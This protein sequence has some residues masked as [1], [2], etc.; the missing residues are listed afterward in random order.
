MSI[1]TWDVAAHVRAD[2]GEGPAWDDRENVLWFVDVT[3]GALYRLDP[4][5]GEVESRL[6]GAPMGSAIPSREGG[7]ILALEDGVHAYSWDDD[8]SRLLVPVEAHDARIRMND[9]KCDPHGRLWAGTMAYEFTPGVSTLYRFDRTGPTPVETGCTIANGMGWSPDTATM[10][11]V[12]SPTSRIDI[13]DYD[14]ET[15]AATD[16]R[17]WV[18]V[19]D[20]AG[21]PDGLT[22]DS[23]GCIW[24]ALWGGGAVRRYAPDGKLIEVVDLP[25][26]Q[27]ASACFGGPSLSDLYV[28]TA[29]YEMTPADIEREPLA[30]ATFVVATDVAGS[31]TVTVD[32]GL[33][34]T[35]T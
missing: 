11:F 4:L 18:T 5:T 1:R 8:A 20:G 13:F 12:D 17:A 2:I 3:P 34:S 33:L 27:V 35:A 9:A 24:V 7:L 23:E 29:A 15:G 31:P 22:V 10:Y 21:S 6:V 14:V 30:G 25:V 32:A 19:E 26:R 28:T 16:R